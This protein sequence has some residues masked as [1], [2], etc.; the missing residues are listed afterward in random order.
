MLTPKEKLVGLDLDFQHLLVKLSQATGTENYV[1]TSGKRD[2]AANAAVGGVKDSAH[3]AGI[4]V[5]IAHG[6]DIIKAMKLAY[7]LGRQSFVR[8]GFYDK[9]LHIDIDKT[10]PQ[11]QWSGVSH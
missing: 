7:W 10:K 2:P 4:A 6:G 9:H 8:V 1:V 5:D 3:E 11:T